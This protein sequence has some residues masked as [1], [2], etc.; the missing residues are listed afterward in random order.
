MP[1][2]EPR[3]DSDADESRLDESRQSRA[4]TIV[5]WMSHGSDKTDANESRLEHAGPPRH[6]CLGRK[7]TWSALFA[8]GQ[9]VGSPYLC[10]T[11][12][13]VQHSATE[14]PGL[15][16]PRAHLATGQAQSVPINSSVTQ[17]GSIICNNVKTGQL[18]PIS[19][20]Y[21]LFLPIRDLL[22]NGSSVRTDALFSVEIGRK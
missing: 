4:V 3:L 11:W 19:T 5:T 13:R 1:D 7:Q 17:G 8:L 21:C 16:V 2:S 12:C 10:G 14:L 22:E 15:N 6:Q 9:H 18:L 20:N